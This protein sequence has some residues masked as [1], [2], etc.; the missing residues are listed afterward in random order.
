MDRT[1]RGIKAELAPMRY[2]HIL[3]AGK[4]GCF[5]GS[6]AASRFVSR[7]ARPK[8]HPPAQ[9]TLDDW[10]ITTSLWFNSCWWRRIRRT[11]SGAR[12]LFCCRSTTSLAR[13]HSARR[14]K[15]FRPSPSLSTSSS[16]RLLLR[17]LANSQTRQLRMSTRRP[18]KS[19]V[20]SPPDAVLGT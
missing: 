7:P 18:M 4:R 9:E 3:H 19:S 10:I 14:L 16:K 5:Q 11:K 6:R 1:C 12:A 17:I 8:D 15:L 20:N 13:W 2:R